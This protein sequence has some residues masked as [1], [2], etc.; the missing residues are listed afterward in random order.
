MRRSQ[1]EE[2]WAN[3][4]VLNRRVV[5][6]RAESRMSDEDAECVLCATATGPSGVS[7]IGGGPDENEEGGWSDRYW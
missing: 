4:A 6:R 1:G 7:M 3:Q 5:P 2:W